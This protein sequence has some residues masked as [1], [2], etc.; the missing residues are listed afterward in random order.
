MKTYLDNMKRSVKELLGYSIQAIDGEK[1]KVNDFL[2]DDETWIIRYLEVDLGT[3]FSENRVLIPR[4]HLSEPHWESK[5]FPVN[6]TIKKI[7]ESPD[8]EFDL[9]VSRAYEK[10]LVKH[11][12]LKPYWP[13]NPHNFGGVTSFYNPQLPL[14]PPVKIEDIEI[15]E[16]SLRSF[17]EIKSYFIKAL[18]DRFGHI[19]D[20]I[21]EDENWQIIY[22]VVDT[23]NIIP[24][25]KRVLLPVEVIEN[26]NYLKQE[27]VINLTKESIEDAPEYDPS[28]AINAEYEKV[29]YDFYGRKRINVKNKGKL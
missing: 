20:L 13:I 11:H 18:D 5:H 10:E 4:E 29:L 8:L 7:E 9:P 15:E 3:L 1:G 25:S 28:M 24:W 17:K 23:L 21:I 6:L 26:I 12:E 14:K 22:V 27:A 19:H 16:T 2:F